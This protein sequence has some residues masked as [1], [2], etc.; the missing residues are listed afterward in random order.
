MVRQNSRSFRG[1]GHLH[2]RDSC[3]QPVVLKARKTEVSCACLKDHSGDRLRL[4]VDRNA[5][6]R[7]DAFQIDLIVSVSAAVGLAHR[8]GGRVSCSTCRCRKCI[9]SFCICQFFINRRF[10]FQNGKIITC[11]AVRDLILQLGVGR[12][13]HLYGSCHSQDGF[14]VIISSLRKTCGRRKLI[15]SCSRYD[16]HVICDAF[17]RIVIS[18]WNVHCHKNRVFFDQ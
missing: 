7:Q 8:D 2:V 15:G 16:I 5:A 10:F 13:S 4:A 1:E 3:S 6:R 14:A 12:S 17:R 11:T 18:K 9:A